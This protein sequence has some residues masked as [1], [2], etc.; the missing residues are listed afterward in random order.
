MYPW[1]KILTIMGVSSL[2]CGG[3]LAP[4]PSPAHAQDKKF[5]VY[6]SM[7][8]TGG[9]WLTAASNSIKAFAAT[10]PYDKMIDFQGVIAGDDPQRKIAAYESMIPRGSDA[11]ITFPISFTALN[12][13]IQQGSEKGVSGFPFVPAL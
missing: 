7:A 1:R 6:L 9:G 3:P 8:V 5:K 4:G 2:L 11:I 13:T 10:P 12:R